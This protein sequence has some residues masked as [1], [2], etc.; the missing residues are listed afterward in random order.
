[1]QK[2]PGNKDAIALLDEILLA[3]SPWIRLTG[4][5]NTDDQPLQ[6][7]TSSLEAGIFLHPL[8]D[9]HVALTVPIFLKDGNTS[10]ALTFEVGDKLSF[11][12]EGLMIAI[13]AGLAQFPG[14]NTTAFTGSVDIAKSFAKYFI[15]TAAAARKPYFYSRSSIDSA[16]IE[17]NFAATAGWNNKHTV[18]GVAGFS[19]SR[20]PDNN[21][22][23]TLYATIYAPE[24]KARNFS[25]QFGY[26]YNNSNSKENR[27]VPQNSTLQNITGVYDPY[28]TPNDQ[29]IHSL[30]TSIAYQPVKRVIIGAAVNYG[31]YAT[32]QN[33]YFFVKQANPITIDKNYIEQKFSPVELGAYV[34]W[35]ATKKINIKAT[36]QYHQTFFY[37]NQYVGLSLKANFWNE[38]K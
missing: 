3:Q 15:L 5:Y 1:M 19:V 21:S 14:N 24:L 29:Q 12:K 7:F 8:A 32:T 34:L 31:L 33:P 10:N 4:A 2:H 25:F 36:Y 20:F 11:N 38:K 13:N 26:G 27:F 17:S 22:V 35:Q 16:L 37:T 18:N 23:T 6:N 9:L 28:F 30:I